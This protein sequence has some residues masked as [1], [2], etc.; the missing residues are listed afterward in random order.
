MD[1]QYAK[2]FAGIA[3]E[4]DTKLDPF[5]VA[6][7]TSYFD[8]VIPLQDTVSRLKWPTIPGPGVSRP[9]RLWALLLFLARGHQEPH[10]DILNLL[11][12]LWLFRKSKGRMK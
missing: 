8:D 5:E 4:M 10:D 7:L 6:A 12:V 11:Q 9:G 2:W 3:N 1:S